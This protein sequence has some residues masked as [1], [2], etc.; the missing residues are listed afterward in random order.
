M[1]KEKEQKPQKP[2][3]PTFPSGRTEKSSQVPIS[4]SDK[5]TENKGKK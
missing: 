4:P 2:V 1:N 5:G 3:K